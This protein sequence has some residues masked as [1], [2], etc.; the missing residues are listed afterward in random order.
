M[1]THTAPRWKSLFLM[2]MM[3][4]VMMSICGVEGVDIV[5]FK[6]TYRNVNYAPHGTQIWLLQDI[7]SCNANRHLTGGG[8]KIYKCKT[9]IGGSVCVPV[10]GSDQSITSYSMVQSHGF[11]G[12]DASTRCI[13]AWYCSW[14][15]TRDDRADY[16]FTVEVQAY[17][18]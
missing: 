16:E 18:S 17:V 8:C 4:A 7:G 1:R 15:K 2:I 11:S 14:V 10:A 12:G 9:P 6:K 13:K 5:V 3:V